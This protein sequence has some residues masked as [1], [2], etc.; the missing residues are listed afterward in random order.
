MESKFILYKQFTLRKLFNMS[1]VNDHNRK[2][3]NENNKH[4]GDKNNRNTLNEIITYEYVIKR[5]WNTNL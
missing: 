4:S 3:T 1:E 2:K 5:K